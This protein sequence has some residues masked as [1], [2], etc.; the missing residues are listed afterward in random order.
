MRHAALLAVADEGGKLA[1]TVG[2][3]VVQQS[4]FALERL[5]GGV[6]AVRPL[7][8]RGRRLGVYDFVLCLGGDG[9]RRRAATE[10]P[11]DAKNF[12]LHATPPPTPMGWFYQSG[13]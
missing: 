4:E 12:T 7:G 1:H 3:G 5:H 8:A 9:P 13:D 11:L 2:D 10:H 6:G